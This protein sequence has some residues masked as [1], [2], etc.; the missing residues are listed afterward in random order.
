MLII[1]K[2]IKQCLPYGIVRARQIDL[3]KE[4]HINRALRSLNGHTYVEIGVESGKCFDKII[5]PRKIG[6]DPA[7]RNFD[8]ESALGESIFKMTSDDFFVEH[9]ERLFRCQRVNVALVD[10]LHEFAQALRDVLNLEKF[11]SPGGVIFIHDC[12]PSTRKYD[13][14]CDGGAWT[15]DVWKVAY[16]LTTYRRDLTFFTLNCDWG[17]GV[18]TGFDPLLNY[19]PPPAEILEQCKKLDYEYLDR[20]RE[21]ILRLRP[22]WYSRMFFR[23]FHGRIRG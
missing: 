1:K 8:S 5:A 12:N 21:Q 11:M 23:I 14:G 4:T 6:I 13:E 7:P 15:G 18:L 16:Y 2:I 3:L 17:L 22:A 10:G 20:K 9:A 19:E